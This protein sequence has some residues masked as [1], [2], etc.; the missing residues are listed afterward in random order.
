MLLV[1]LLIMLHVSLL[2]FELEFSRVVFSQSLV[3]RRNFFTVEVF[4]AAAV[5]VAEGE[6][7]MIE[8]CVGWL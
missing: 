8:I 7:L 2:F 1:L 6:E 5:E 4:V 3:F